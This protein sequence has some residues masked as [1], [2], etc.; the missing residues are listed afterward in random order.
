MEQLTIAAVARLA[1]VPAHTLRKWESRHGIGTPQRTPTGRRVY[2]MSH[3]ELLRL[4]RLLSDNG[5]SLT[6]LAA[7]DLEGLK[8][9][10]AILPLWPCLFPF[11]IKIEKGGLFF[12]RGLVIHKQWEFLVPLIIV[13]ELLPLVIV[14]VH[15]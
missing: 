2:D 15:R 8:S 7:L 14:G 11:R 9:L 3:V 4:I 6:H 1:G 10:A 5:H 12:T 13:P